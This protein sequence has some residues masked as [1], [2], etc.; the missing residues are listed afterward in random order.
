MSTEAFGEA[1]WVRALAPAKINATLEVL[2]KREDGFH[3]LR[4]HMV[5]LELA[6]LVSVRLRDDDEFQLQVEGP[7][8]S[9]DIPRDPSNLVAR[10]AQ[11]ALRVLNSSAG[12]DVRLVK[13][14]PSQAGLGG[15]SSDAAAA[16]LA[17]SSALKIPI[18]PVRL[19]AL[20]ASLGSDCVFFA[21]AALT[22]AALCEGRGE[23]VSPEAS[24]EP[25]WSVSLVVPEVC[26]DTSSVYAAHEFS[27]RASDHGHSLHEEVLQFTAVKARQ[28]I[29][30]DLQQSAMK[31]FPELSSWETTL[32][33]A[34]CGH[35]RMTGSG[36]TF[37]GLHE[38]AEQAQQANRAILAQAEADGLGVRASF[39]TRTSNRGARVVCD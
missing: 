15:G 31:S 22:G 30:N 18:E 16:I 14:V 9:A 5:C 23:R 35:F 36:A 20:L 2:G 37:F 7:Y 33:C 12:L 11:A 39:V 25:A 6:D 29:T 27:L 26:A 21:S 3:E 10:A 19:E 17:T 38:T 24:P 8:A 32:E 28:W 1:S 34:G 4:T 13:N